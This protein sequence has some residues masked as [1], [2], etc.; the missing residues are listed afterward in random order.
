MSSW[1]TDRSF[2]GFQSTFCTIT[3][4]QLLINQTAIRLSKVSGLFFH[5]YFRGNLPEVVRSRLDWMSTVY[6]SPAYEW[7]RMP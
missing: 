6:S 2:H 5:C 7:L 1:R 4:D 3:H